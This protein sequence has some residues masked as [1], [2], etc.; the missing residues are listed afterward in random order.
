MQRFFFFIL[1]FVNL[2][3]HA[4]DIDVQHYRFELTVSD[5]NDT[6]F[7]KAVIT[8]RL[9][10]GV[11][12]AALNLASVVNGKGMQVIG[13]QVDS[14]KTRFS[15]AADVLTVT[16]PAVKRP[17][18]LYHISIQYKGVPKD[19]LIISKNKWGQRTFFADNWPNRAQQWI[20]CVDRPDDKLFQTGC[21]KANAALATALP[22]RIGKKSFRSLQR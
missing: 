19:G 1:L 13:V 5:E 2:A 4:Q 15:H 18:S 12:T 11:K 8:T 9:R 10:T 7:G 6:L 3:V 21:C 22:A 17:D 14:V 20:P 16:M